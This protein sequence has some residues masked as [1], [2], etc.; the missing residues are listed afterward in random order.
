LQEFEGLHE[1]VASSLAVIEDEAARLDRE[2]GFPEC[3]FA[4]LREA[5]ALIAPLPQRLGGGGIGTEPEGAMALLALLRLIGRGSLAV[6][7][8]YEGHV[9]ALKLIAVYGT[10]AQLRLAAGDAAD[11]QLFG[12]WV[13]G[14]A[15]PL[16]LVE[17][18]ER[19]RLEG[20][21]RF[22]SGALHVTRPLVTASPEAGLDRMLVVP[23]GPQ[24]KAADTLGGLHGMRAAR[25]GSC[26]FTG[27]ELGAEALIGAPGDYLRQPEFSAGAWRGIA[28]ALGGIDRLV[29]LLRN[30]LRQR[31]RHHN[32]HQLA[33]IGEALIAR[34]T[35]AMWAA[36]AATAAESGTDDPG[37]VAAIVGLA[38]IAA[39]QA[40]L[41]VIRLVQRGLGLAGFL[42]DNPVER[43]MRDLATYLRQPAPDETL[44]EAAAWFGEREMPADRDAA[45]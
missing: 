40:G 10:E 22:A 8:L 7:R 25:T 15:A 44:T 21:K 18:R 19:Y 41:D 13:T 39:E 45:S 3:A 23:L 24:R 38:R 27:I 37:D 5:G 33:R 6:G 4:L 16:R 26:D 43:V 32:P 9:N 11:G 36:R 20:E 12:I 14:G 42:Q 34:E 28:V 35:A 2:G 1:R 30:Q 31:G 29:S 17:T